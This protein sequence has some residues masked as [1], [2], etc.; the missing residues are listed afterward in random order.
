MQNSVVSHTVCAHVQCRRSQNFGYARVPLPWDAGVADP[1]KTRSFP[2]VL[3]HQ[4]WSL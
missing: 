4:M 3:S 2:R 1:L